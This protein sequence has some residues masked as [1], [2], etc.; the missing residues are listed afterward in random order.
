MIHS[1][2]GFAPRTSDEVPAKLN[3]DM[4]PALH[5]KPLTE[6]SNLVHAPQEHSL[7]ARTEAAMARL[8]KEHPA[9]DILVN[10]APSDPP[11]V[12]EPGK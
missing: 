6:S 3:A 12:L 2:P 4:I 11:Q 8:A 1:R 5:R 7:D 10:P 9:P